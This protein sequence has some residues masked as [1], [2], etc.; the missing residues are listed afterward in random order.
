MR[1]RQ[2][3]IGGLRSWLRDQAEERNVRRA[4]LTDGRTK[5]LLSHETDALQVCM[6]CVAVW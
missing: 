4:E 1:L 6:H 5:A 2:F 3:S